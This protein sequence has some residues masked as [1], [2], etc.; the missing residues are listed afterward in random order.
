MPLRTTLKFKSSAARLSF[1]CIWSFLPCSSI[2]FNHRL[3]EGPV[4]NQSLGNYYCSALLW[5]GPQLGRWGSGGQ[6][7]RR[8]PPPSPPR[9]HAAGSAHS[10]LLFLVA[11]TKVWS[12][13]QSCVKSRFLRVHPKCC[14]KSLTC[15]G[16]KSYLSWRR[17]IDRLLRSACASC[18]FAYTVIPF[19]PPSCRQ[20]RHCSAVYFRILVIL[21]QSHCPW[22]WSLVFKATGRMSAF[23]LQVLVIAALRRRRQPVVCFTGQ[24]PWPL[25]Q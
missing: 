10:N 11:A 23:K 18:G 7:P 1:S 24:R 16:F 13:V 14:R 25:Y 21:W 20:E 17:G 9:G 4:S 5:P 6:G 8:G 12:S 2:Q 3:L 22:A 15:R 19:L